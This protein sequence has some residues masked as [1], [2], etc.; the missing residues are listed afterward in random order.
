MPK[1]NGRSPEKGERAAERAALSPES[2]GREIVAEIVNDA[3]ENAMFGAAE[4]RALEKD[5][6]APSPKRGR[7]A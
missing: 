5:R 7:S 4:G 1:L 3:V 6:R 2:K